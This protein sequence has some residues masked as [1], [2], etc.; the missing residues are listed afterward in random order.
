MNHKIIFCIL[1]LLFLNSCSKKKF[2]KTLWNSDFIDDKITYENRNEMLDDLLQ[3]YKLEG[4]TISEIENILGKFDEH[5]F[6]DSANI[7]V[8]PVLVEWK[9]IDPYKYKYLNLNYSK[10]G[11]IDSVYVTE[12][13]TK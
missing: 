4:K 3:N 12:Y 8:I 7:I 11:V 10:K 9:G 1:S 5:S 13:V 6:S 2:D